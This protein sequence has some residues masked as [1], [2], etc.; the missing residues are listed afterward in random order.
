[1]VSTSVGGVPEVLPEDMMIL[2][3]A[4]PGGLMKAVERAL[5]R[6]ASLE[7][8]KGT[9]EYCSWRYERAME[10]HTSVTTMYSWSVVASRTEKVYFDAIKHDTKS[11]VERFHRYHLCGKWF[12]KICVLLAVVDWLLL[13]ALQ[14][15]RPAH[16][17]LLQKPDR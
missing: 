16:K 1:M 2:A 3:D 9:D 5:D 14:V 15:V 8:S 17:I 13:L 6:V 10:Q 4:S 11:L 12:G 7:S